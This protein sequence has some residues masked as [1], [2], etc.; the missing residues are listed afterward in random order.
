MAPD[1]ARVRSSNDDEDDRMMIPLVC[2]YYNGEV[3]WRHVRIII[4]IHH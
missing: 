2:L 3:E 4:T 1:A